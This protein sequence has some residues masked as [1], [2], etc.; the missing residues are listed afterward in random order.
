VADVI[1]TEG[2]RPLALPK[3]SR[4]RARIACANGANLDAEETRLFLDILGLLDDTTVLEV[5]E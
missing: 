5:G 3:G 1:L 2:V 4:Q